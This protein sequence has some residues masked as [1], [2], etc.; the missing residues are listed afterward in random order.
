EEPSVKG[1]TQATV[2]ESSISEIGAAMRTLTANQTIAS[3]F[4]LENHQVFAKQTDRLE[5]V[6]AGKFVDQRRRLPI[7]SHQAA[8][9]PGQ[10]GSG[11]EII[12]LCTQHRKIPSANVTLYEVAEGLK[13]EAG[14]M[15]DRKSG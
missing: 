13:A 5:R 4:V 8:R 10:P 3:V 14:T 12:L 11:D 6:I 7:A 15:A 1:T 2:F 9:G